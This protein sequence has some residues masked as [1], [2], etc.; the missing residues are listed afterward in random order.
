M[1][2]L[3]PLLALAAGRRARARKA[4]VVRPREITLH[5]DVARVLRDHCLPEWIWFHVPNGER[6]DVRT[7]ARLKK[8]GVKPGVP[9]FL[10]I[11]PHGSV[12]LL[13][14]KRPGESLSEPQEDFRIHCVKHG[15]AHAIAYDFSQALTALNAWQCLRIRIGGA[16]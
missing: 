4:P 6:R 12:R 7:G 8:M 10:L 16:R 5:L 14:L 13:E 3:P 2:A 15:I 1:S 9:D 11:S